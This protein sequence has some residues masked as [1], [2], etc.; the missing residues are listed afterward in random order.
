MSEKRVKG[1]HSTDKRA[2]ERGVTN[3]MK[4]KSEI[5]SRRKGH[6]PREITSS[7]P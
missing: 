2:E 7:Y 3:G 4:T 6:H 1:N 5:E